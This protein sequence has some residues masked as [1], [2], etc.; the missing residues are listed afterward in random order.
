MSVEEAKARLLHPP[1]EPA[2]GPTWLQ[3]NALWL[4]PVAAAAGFLVARPRKIGRL[5]G[6]ALS[7]VKSPMV[8]KAALSFVT[9][10]SRRQVH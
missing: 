6:K 5:S 3:K 7:L 9:N 2:A 8:Q 1:E 10:L 4:V